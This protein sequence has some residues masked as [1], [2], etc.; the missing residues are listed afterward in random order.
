[1][2]SDLRARLAG[3]GR[4]RI[5]DNDAL[6]DQTKPS[7]AVERDDK[8]GDAGDS[9]RWSAPEMMNPDKF[10]FTKN[11]VAKLPS[12]STDIYAFG[13]TILEVSPHFQQPWPTSSHSF[14]I[15]GG[16]HRTPSIWPSPGSK[17]HK[18]GDRWDSSGETYRWVHRRVVETARAQ[19]VGGI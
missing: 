11:R 17:H 5:I 15:S 7:T 16:S 2:D 10:G 12:K 19:L 6:E 1:M 8:I 4:M 18:E 3:F 14:A 13:M 9:I